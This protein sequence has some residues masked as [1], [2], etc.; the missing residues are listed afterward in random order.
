MTEFTVEQYKYEKC[1]SEKHNAAFGIEWCLKFNRPVVGS[2]FESLKPVDIDQI[3]AD[4]MED[5]DDDDD[6][7]DEKDNDLA[8]RPR[9][10]LSGPYRYEIKY[11]NPQK[12]KT[13]TLD[14]ER[15]KDQEEGTYDVQASLGTVSQAG[16]TKNTLELIYSSDY[17]FKFNSI[18]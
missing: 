16:E 11:R 18:L 10:S 7:D 13:I 9:I 17:F 1:T 6:E 3:L 15:V 2:L 4:E 5:D 8:K 12:T 14:F